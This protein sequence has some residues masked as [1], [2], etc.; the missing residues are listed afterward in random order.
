MLRHSVVFRGTAL[1]CVVLVGSLLWPQLAAADP[2]PR[3]ATIRETARAVAE[4]RATELKVREARS[5][6]TQ[7]DLES[8]SFFKT[9]VGIAV[10]AAFGVGVGYALYSASN[11]RIRSAGR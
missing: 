6:T 5:Q 4:R 1:A 3:P 7:A 8:A 2:P 10:L 11:D 9:P